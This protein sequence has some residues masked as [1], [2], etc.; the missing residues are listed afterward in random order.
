M[1]KCR[2]FFTNM[3]ESSE[4]ACSL[5]YEDIGGCPYNTFTPSGIAALSSLCT[6]F[7]VI[8]LIIGA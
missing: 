4:M 5:L 7:A 2:K 8:S 6:V 3:V 1:G